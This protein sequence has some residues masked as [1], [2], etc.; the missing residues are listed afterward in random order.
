MNI[1]SIFTKN[2]PFFMMVSICMGAFISHFTAGVVNVSL[3]HLSKIFSHQLRNGTM[4]YD[5]L[6]TSHRR[7]T[8]RKM[9]IYNANTF[10]TSLMGRYENY[11]FVE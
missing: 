8:V 9:R 2:K 1:T 10:D 7:G 11:F 4:D 3:P 5:W 6:F